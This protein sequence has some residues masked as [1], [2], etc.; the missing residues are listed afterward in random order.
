MEVETDGGGTDGR[1]RIERIGGTGVRSTRPNQARTTMRE[2]G[3][4]VLSCWTRLH[5]CGHP[6]VS[7][8]S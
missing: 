7:G 3:S 8:A 5:C 6:K 4:G 2:R 1:D